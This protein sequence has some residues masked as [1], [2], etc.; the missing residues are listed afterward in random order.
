MTNK[1]S[2]LFQKGDP[3]IPGA[4]RMPGGYNF[5]ASFVEPEKAVLH[6][7]DLT[8]G[9]EQQICMK[10]GTVTGAG[11]AVFVSCP[12]SARLQYF[13]TLN[14]QIV[15]DPYT[16]WISDGINRALPGRNS[17]SGE[18]GRGASIRP[19]DMILYKLHVR[20]FTMNDPSVPQEER[21]TWKGLERKIPYLKDLGINTVELMPV[22]TFDPVLPNGRRN[23]W[24][25]AENNLYFAPNAAYAATDD[26]VHEITELIGAFHEA[27]IACILDFY[28]PENQSVRILGDALRYWIMEI[29]ADGFHL[30]GKNSPVEE[31][32]QDP[33]L[34]DRILLLDSPVQAVSER[35]QFRSFD[36]VYT[37]QHEFRQMARKFLAGRGDVTGS[38]AELFR[39][40]PAQYHVVNYI[41][42]HNGF[43]LQ[44]LVSY[45]EKRNEANGEGNWD[46]SWDNDSWNCG[47][48]GPTEKRN[49]NALRRRQIRNAL[50]L[51]FLSQGIPML[52]A[53]DEFGNT[54]KG[55]NN[56]YCLDNEDG[57][58][59]WADASRNKER[60]RFV[61]NLI[62]FRRD[63]RILHTGYAMWG[64]DYEHTG[65]PDISFHGRE[66]FSLESGIPAFAVLLNGHY[67]KIKE[68]A[69]FLVMN[70]WD[71]PYEFA[72][73][74][75]PEGYI[76]KKAVTSAPSSA[77]KKKQE[78]NDMLSL[79]IP[80]H[81][82]EIYEGVPACRS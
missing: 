79:V 34:A 32:L 55:N 9:L 77:K 82:I 41:A 17:F 68:N 1:D 61:R 8:S 56:A 28:I 51:V 80:A 25:F 69:L 10:E 19:E 50:L 43:T 65:M 13:F 2:F 81:T 18:E 31:T 70:A 3:L 72:L 74:S 12:D 4:L 67:A 35:Q 40:C 58:L 64:S 57:W 76:W 54:Q 45:N 71:Q 7:K 78:E 30:S 6:I 20:G 42:D 36:H 16:K 66:K 33:Y 73:P 22:Y 5:C 24:G 49:V 59:D 60:I 23:Y 11:A 46:G 48:E 63:H 15:P 26:P 38:F 75:L 29:G 47:E 14:G 52:Y 62:R 21:G 53:G 27:G 44:D 37:M 39:C